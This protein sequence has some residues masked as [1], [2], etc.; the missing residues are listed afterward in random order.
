M[1]QAHPRPRRR[2]QRGI[3]R[4]PSRIS[5]YLVPPHVG[6]RQDQ[7]GDLPRLVHLHVVAGI[8]EQEQLGRRDSSWNRLATRLFRYGSAAPR[9]MRTG[10]ME[11][12]QPRDGG[13]P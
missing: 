13:R 9:M 4:C 5:L 7:P 2:N 10:R 6:D 12:P 8:R 11:P 1:G 3:S